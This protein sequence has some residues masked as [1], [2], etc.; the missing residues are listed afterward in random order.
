MDNGK[1]FEMNSVS[2]GNGLGNINYRAQLLKGNCTIETAP[3][4]GVTITCRFPLTIFS[5]K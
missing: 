3:G 4:S 5:S 2:K 1:G